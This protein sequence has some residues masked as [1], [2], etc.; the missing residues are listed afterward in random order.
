MQMVCIVNPPLSPVAAVFNRAFEEGE[1]YLI[2]MEMD[3]RFQKMGRNR[4]QLIFGILFTR[5]NLQN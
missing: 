1:V 4:L 2:P 5:G 3:N